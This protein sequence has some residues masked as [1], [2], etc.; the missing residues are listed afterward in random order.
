MPV[1]FAG[2]LLLLAAACGGEPGGV[3][4]PELVDT[5]A[6]EPACDPSAVDVPY[7]GFDG[8]CD[9][10]DDYDVDGDGQTA[11]AW[12]GGDCDDRDPAIYTGAPRLC[13]DGLDNDCDHQPDCDLRGELAYADVAAASFSGTENSGPR[14]VA[15]G[16]VDGDGERD[17]LLASPEIN[18]SWY[19]RG[20]LLDSR[21]AAEADAELPGGYGGV[22]LGDLDGDGLDD[23]AINSGGFFQSA[24]TGVWWGGDTL[25]ASADVTGGHESG[26]ATVAMDITIA[27]MDGDGLGDL[28]TSY[29]GPLLDI[30]GLSGGWIVV[31]AGPLQ[32]PAFDDEDRSALLIGDD[33]G[34]GKAGVQM[35]ARDDL[36]G[37]G[38]VDLA[39]A[40]NAGDPAGNIY[41]VET[42][43]PVTTYLVDTPIAYHAEDR[44]GG[45]GPITGALDTGDLDGDGSPDLLFGADK[46]GF[47]FRGPLTDEMLD[48]EVWLTLPERDYLVLL[49]ATGDLDG[50]GWGDVALV[51]DEHDEV[52]GNHLATRVFYAP[53][54]AVTEPDLVLLGGGLGFGPEADLDHDGLADLVVPDP[55]ATFDGEILGAA[56]VVLGRQTGF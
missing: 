53:R 31:Q 27:D 20:P 13:G 54:G 29:L 30:P 12:G 34:F 38:L 36:T 1:A 6:H 56:W 25:S 49:A 41:V 47:A 4:E 55:S 14:E 28:V 9:G 16:D 17:L 40:D 51:S 8:D 19:F 44:L 18:V 5:G 52:F 2:P 35:C 37:D 22:A 26:D 24:S 42:P 23:L 10:S 43:L 7:D 3:P 32:A 15:L 39:I 50:D 45:T 11:E 46:Q 33:L 21:T 48:A